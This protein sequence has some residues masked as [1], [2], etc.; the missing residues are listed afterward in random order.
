[1]QML[2]KP[3]PRVLYALLIAATIVIGL[4]VHARI[5]PMPPPLRK[6]LGDTLWAL[7]VFWILG[8]IF[9]RWSLTRIALL[10]FCFSALVEISQ[11]YHAPGIDS[12]RDTI[13]GRLVLGQ[14]FNWP[15][16]LAYAAGV[17]LGVA[18]ESFLL[19]RPTR[20]TAS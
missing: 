10:A 16:F 2:T 12:L 15:D 3:R 20:Q 13:F 19:R 7:N 11:L 5:I 14:T 8:F 9:N 6:Y 4:T 17:C 1:M 18:L